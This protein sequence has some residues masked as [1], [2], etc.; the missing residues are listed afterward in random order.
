ILGTVLLG[1]TAA[2][3]APRAREA[4][5]PQRLEGLW[6]ELASTDPSQALAALLAL[7]EEPEASVNLL[8]TRLK[9]IRASR[10][11]IDQW[12]ADLS[13]PQFGARTR[14]SAELERVVDIAAPQM[15]KALE[16]GPSLEL[17]HRLE[18]VLATQRP[19]GEDAF[20]NRVQAVRAIALLEQ[21]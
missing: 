17:R 2:G 3:E 21:V 6:A 12:I 10:A 16:D 19:G 18:R 13:S 11:L 9:P 20:P 14:A 4:A 8:K 1:L 5:G 15:R 7:A